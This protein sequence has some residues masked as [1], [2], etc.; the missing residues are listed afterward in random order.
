MNHCYPD[1]T[2]AKQRVLERSEVHVPM[3]VGFT[4]A[5]YDDEPEPALR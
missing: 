3:L 1:P 2:A 5:R 4:V